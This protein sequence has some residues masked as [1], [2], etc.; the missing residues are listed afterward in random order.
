MLLFESIVIVHQTQYYTLESDGSPQVGIV[1]PHVNC[2]A[3][4]KDVYHCLMF[5]VNYGFYKFGLEVSGWVLVMFSY[6]ERS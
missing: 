3:A 1:F 6:P 2:E 4:T 5:F